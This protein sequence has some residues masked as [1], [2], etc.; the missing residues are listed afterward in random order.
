M[1][2]LVSIPKVT[3][4]FMVPS[5][6][7]VDWMYSMRS[8]PFICCS[9]GVATDCSMVS[10]SAPVYVVVRLICGGR[11]C[12]NCAIGSPRSATA[13]MSTVMIAMTIATM[14]RRM[15]KADM[16]DSSPL[17]SSSVFHAGRAR[18]RARSV[19]GG[20]GF[21]I[22]ERAFGDFLDALDD[23]A[24]ALR[25]AFL[26]DL[27]PVRARPQLHFLQRNFVVGPD[28]RD[29]ERPL[30]GDERLV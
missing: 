19:L 22:D 30:H 4:R 29:G 27:E 26:D 9:I 7:L 25:D 21:R 24:V 13:P 2:A 3:V 23:D 18:R 20:H 16:V 17:V 10:A 8:T 6:A 1:F 5:F 15:K 12:G 28:D 14:G 11:I